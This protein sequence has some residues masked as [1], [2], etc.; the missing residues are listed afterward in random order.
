MLITIITPSRNQ[1]RYIK[2]CLE[3]IHG[4]THKEIEH[5]ILDGMSTDNTVA[6]V[7]SYPS[8]FIQRKDTGPAQ[9]INCGLDMANGEVVCWLNSDDLFFGPDTLRF[10]AAIF[11][12]HPNVDVVTGNGYYM[13]DTGRLTQPVVPSHPNRMTEEWMKRHDMFLQPAT[14]WRRNALRLDEQ[15]HFGFDWQLWIEFYRAGLNVLY[16]PQYLALYR[17]HPESLTQQD[18]PARRREIYELIAKYGDSKAQ[19]IWCW[20]VWKAYCVDEYLP[21]NFL[22]LIANLVNRAVDKITSGKIAA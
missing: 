16:L 8:R 18:P 10:V 20:I 15:L 11:Q 6:V 5:I 9:A 13:T 22:R 1:G 19:V 12:Q 17:V 2:D 21:G 3:S 7:A 14:F 4:Q